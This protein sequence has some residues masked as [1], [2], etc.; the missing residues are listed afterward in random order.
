MGLETVIKDI[1]SAAQ[2]EVNVINADADAEVS[3][4]LDDARQTAKKIMGDRLAKA[5]DDIKR[6]RQQEIS[7]ANLEVKRAMLN[8]R[9][10]VLDKVYNNAIDSIVSLPGSK[11]E[12]LLKAIIDE[13][14]SNGSNIYSNKDSE[15]LVRKLSSLEYAGNI[16]CIGGLTIENSD[17]TVRLDY[18]YDMILKNVNEQSLKQTS[19]ILF[20]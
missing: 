1:M 13:N 15:K 10:E 11:Q 19:D 8:A 9:K 16:D 7:S 18:T 5:E 4:I 6:L 12:E 3:Q 2:T 14:D 20:G 17:G